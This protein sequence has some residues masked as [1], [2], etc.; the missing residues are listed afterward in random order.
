[1]TRW[2]ERKFEPLKSHLSFTGTLER[3]HGTPIRLEELISRIPSELYCERIDD[4]WSMQENAGHLYDLEPLWLG[5]IQDFMQARET[6]RPADLSNRKTDEA[7]HHS[8]DIAKILADF[9]AA[10]VQL[11]RAFEEM[12]EDR[13]TR[14]AL[15]PRLKTAMLP[16]DLA[17]FVAEHDDHHLARIRELWRRYR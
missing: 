3:L 11:V 9:R 5:R 16:I 12:P 6:L 8:K 17:F 13:R 4:T 14:T 15:H 10:R 7:G 2:F 1:M